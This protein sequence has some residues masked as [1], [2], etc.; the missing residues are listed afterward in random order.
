MS[1][2]AKQPGGDAH[3]P[4][5][6]ALER[7]LD[8]PLGAR[9]DPW[10]T[11]RV[12]VPD[13]RIWS[14]V[15]V[16]GFKPRFSARYGDDAFAAATVIYKA[17]DGPNDP[18]R[19][20][21]RIVD[22]NVPLARAF[23]IRPNF[24]DKVKLSHVFGGEDRPLVVWKVDGSIENIL[25]SDDYAGAIAS[26]TSWPGTCLVIAFAVKS[27]RHPELARKVRDRWVLDAAPRFKWERNVREAPPLDGPVPKEARRDPKKG[28][29]EIVRRI[30]ARPGQKK[31][32]P[33]AFRDRPAPTPGAKPR[34]DAP[35][36]SELDC[37]TKSIL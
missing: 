28:K 10:R 32:P 14:H 9:V 6:A 36:K 4:E 3:D 16:F 26:Y 22:D 7:L 24:G 20:L 31:L 5:L 29:L 33:K 2:S 18:E 17:S 21:K 19:C 23:G 30:S 27:T 15:E 35:P 13:W 25:V 11:V 12:A 8:A 37:G 34:I 1:I